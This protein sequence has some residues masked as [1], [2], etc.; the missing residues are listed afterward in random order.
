MKASKQHRRR[1]VVMTNWRDCKH[2]EA[3]GAELVCER[4]A[5]GFVERGHDVVLLTS[6][7]AGERRKEQVDGYWIVRR[8]GRFTVYPVGAGM[9]AD[10]P[11]VHP[12]GD[13]QPERHSVLHPVGGQAKDSGVDAAA[14]RPSGSVPALLSAAGFQDRPMVGTVWSKPRVPRP[15]DHRHL[16]LD[17]EGHSTPAWVSRE[18]SW[19]FPPGRIRQSRRCRASVVG[20]PLPASSASLDWS[21]TNRWPRS[22]D[23]IPSVLSE[24]PDFGAPRGGGRP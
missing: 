6:A 4:L 22:S 24:F 15:D 7:V 5:R 13:R 12:R 16:T 8:G 23:A 2:P 3:G 9:D 18:T 10:V 20:R 14:P 11:E 19:S 1:L 17:P 21:H